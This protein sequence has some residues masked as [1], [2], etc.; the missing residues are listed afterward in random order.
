MPWLRYF[1]FVSVP[2]FSLT[3]SKPEY[4]YLYRLVCMYTTF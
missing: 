3:V 1:C 2:F 4:L